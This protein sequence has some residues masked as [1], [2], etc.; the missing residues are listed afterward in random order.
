MNFEK[1][2]QITG[3]YDKRHHDPNQNY[4]IHGMDIRFLLI[5][6]KGAVQFLV[7]TNMFLPHVSDEIWDGE[8]GTYNRFKPIG[9]D[10]GYHSKEPGYEGHEASECDLFGSCYYDG[11]S[12]QA[13]EFMPTFL[14]GGDKV[15]WEMLEKRYKEIFG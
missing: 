7:M 9:A 5:G 4:G 11:S 15:V 8:R 1:K 14:A 6:D 13:D 10:I 3:A 2:I 12:L